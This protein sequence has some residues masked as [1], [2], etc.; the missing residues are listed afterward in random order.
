MK[1]DSN[2]WTGLITNMLHWPKNINDTRKK[3]NPSVMLG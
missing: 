1:G 2:G 3:R